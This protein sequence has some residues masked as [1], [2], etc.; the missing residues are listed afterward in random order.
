VCVCARAHFVRV[1]MCMCVFLA[2]CLS[3]SHL[4]APRAAWQ[5]CAAIFPGQRKQEQSHC[6]IT[7]IFIF[8]FRWR[9]KARSKV[10]DLVHHSVPNV[11]SCGECVLLIKF[12]RF[13]LNRVCPPKGTALVRPYVCRRSLAPPSFPFPNSSHPLSVSPSLPPPSLHPFVPPC[14]AHGRVGTHS[15]THT[16]IHSTHKSTHTHTRGQGLSNVTWGHGQVASDKQ[17]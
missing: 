4:C 6:I 7:F 17:H 9:A 8:I 16:R 15:S 11:L 13:S 2:L 1:C 10:M 12:V 3:L 5:H 14:T